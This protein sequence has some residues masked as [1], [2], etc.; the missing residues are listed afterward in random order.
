M[1]AFLEGLDFW[2]WWILAVLL[3]VLELAAP[4]IVFLWMA[5]AAALTGVVAWIL[6]DLGW[7]LAFVIFA[8]LSVVS[9]VI[10]RKVWRPSN[11]ET[12]DPTLNKRADQYIGKTFTLDTALENGRGRLHVGDGSWMA[13][14]PDLPAGAKVRVIAVNGSILEVEA[15]E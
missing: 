1:E 13:K 3:F 4:G 9:V 15:A 2:A 10:G 12:E 11:V 6:P 7:Q 5:L 14:G 8:L